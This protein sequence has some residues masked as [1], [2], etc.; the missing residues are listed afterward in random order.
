[1][2]DKFHHSYGRRPF[3]ATSKHP[4]GGYRSQKQYETNPTENISAMTIDFRVLDGRA[5]TRPPIEK[6]EIEAPNERNEQE[7]RQQPEHERFEL[8][9][10]VAGNISGR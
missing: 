4:Y 5:T 9:R 1:V 2:P 8:R 3:P 10:H 7:H 6:S